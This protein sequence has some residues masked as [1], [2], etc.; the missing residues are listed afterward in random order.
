MRHKNEEH[1]T[2]LTNAVAQQLPTINRISINKNHMS[3]TL[4]LLIGI[5]N[6]IVEGLVHIG[7]SMFVLVVAI[8]RELGIMHLVTGS[9]SYKTASG[10]VK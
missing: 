4:H 5:N 7:A 10:V 9:K 2:V 6:Y 8:V 3:K 1:K